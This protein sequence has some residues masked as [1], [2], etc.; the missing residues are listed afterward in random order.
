M[1]KSEGYDPDAI[2]KTQAIS[3][4]GKNRIFYRG[5]TNKE[6]KDLIVETGKD[7]KKEGAKNVKVKKIKEV[8][9]TL[10]FQ[11]NKKLSAL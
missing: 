8:L 7:L 5:L 2:H 9:F 1:K 4:G 6:F 10:P 3:K 11:R